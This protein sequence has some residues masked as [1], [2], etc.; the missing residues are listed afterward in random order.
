[1]HPSLALIFR[2]ALVLVTL[3]LCISVVAPAAEASQQGEAFIASNIQKGMA[4]LNDR[5]LSES[6]RREGFSH[7][8]IGLTDMKR[9]ALYTL[10]QYRRGA[11]PADLE[12][13]QSAFQDYASAVYQSY[14]S[15]YSG[16]S[17]KVI[18]SMPGTSS[19]N[20]V[21][22][23][24]L[25]DPNERGQQPA[26]VDFRVYFDRGAPAVL[27]FSYGGIWLA[28]TERNDFTGFLG[29]NGGDIHAL[30][31]HLTEM[32]RQFRSGGRPGRQE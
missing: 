15:R 13:F 26:E 32:A 2:R 19:T 29:Q 28:E 4:I 24:Q 17:L 22:R 14:F 18:G 7:F 5:G 25:I 21:V 10:G 12:A 8:L 16:Q 31:N 11:S 9:I 20:E 6:Q 30:V 23:T 3:A 27:D 1:M